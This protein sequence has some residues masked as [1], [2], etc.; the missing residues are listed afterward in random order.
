M[1][2]SNTYCV[3]PHLGM[4]LQN[5]SDFCCCNIN[6]ESWKNHKRE[7]M[8]VYNST[9]KSVFN[10]PS[11][12]IIAASLD[13]GIQHSSCRPCWDSESVGNQSA[14]QNFNKMFGDVEPS[15]DQPRVLIIKPGNTCN[16]ACRM[17]NPET[18]S[19]WYQDAYNF[20][21]TNL[22]F[23][24]YTRQFETIR[25]SFNADHVEFWNEL[26]SW[27]KNLLYIDIYGGEPFLSP[28]MFD[29]LEHGINIGCSKDVELQ[30]H[31]NASIF[32]A[33]YLDIL[34]QYKK[35][36]FRVSIDSH[37]PEQLEYIRHKADYDLVINNTIKFK[38]LLGESPNVNMKIT[39][40]VNTLNVLHV[41]Q[42]TQWLTDTFKLP[43]AINIV[44]TP[45]YD[46]RHLPIPVKQYL[47]KNI[48][49][50]QVTSFLQQT[51]PDSDIE[52]ARFCKITDRLDQ[53]RKQSFSKTFPD[54]W[55]MLE[56]HWVKSADIL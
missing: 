43:V 20:E 35:V 24:E 9:L 34:K 32:N 52:W 14:R 18:S 41:D 38:K 1:N 3:M 7:V 12:K 54:W 2:K 55:T 10:N 50:T 6:S 37:I 25:N 8:Y 21:P 28:A 51:I 16:F 11:R 44:Y 49:S 33:R 31:T 40:T 19:S 5:D 47:I 22:S 15:P 46:I 36:N 39:N 56:P 4:A 26:K 48:Q 45:E 42:T 30:I 53:L 27:I 13:H 17:C 23:N 29:L